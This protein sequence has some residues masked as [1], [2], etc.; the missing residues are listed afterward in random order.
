MFAVRSQSNISNGQY[1]KSDAYSSQDVTALV[2]PTV[3]NLSSAISVC[4]HKVFNIPYPYRFIVTGAF[5][6]A[7][8]CNTN[9]KN[10]QQNI[11]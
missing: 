9:L 3:Q 6:G 7:Y 1:K 8:I 2:T 11:L 10:Y 5:I 4:S